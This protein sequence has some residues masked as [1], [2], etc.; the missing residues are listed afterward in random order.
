MGGM[1]G[2]GEVGMRR[3]IGGLA[4]YVYPH[5]TPS[6]FLFIFLPHTRFSRSIPSLHFLSTF[7]KN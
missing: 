6:P 2:V 4:L 5:I 7:I 1:G 3:G